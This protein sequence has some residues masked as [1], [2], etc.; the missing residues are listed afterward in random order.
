M[1][2]AFLILD[3]WVTKHIEHREK[4]KQQCQRRIEKLSGE[5][6][7]SKK[8][9]WRAGVNQSSADTEGKPAGG[10]SGGGRIC[11]QV[12]GCKDYNNEECF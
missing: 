5:A 6:E 7:W 2:K 4:Y 12:P 9:N 8:K 11:F 3:F 10:Q 1:K